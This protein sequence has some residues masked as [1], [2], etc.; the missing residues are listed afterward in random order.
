MI[1]G[2]VY[3]VSQIIYFSHFEGICKYSNKKIVWAI[4]YFDLSVWAVCDVVLSTFQ[5]SNWPEIWLC[6]MAFADFGG[7]LDTLLW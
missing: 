7:E 1:S 5:E 3:A 2:Y 4:K 6:A